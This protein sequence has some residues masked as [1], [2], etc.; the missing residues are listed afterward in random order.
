M[1]TAGTY[2]I[3]NEGGFI[4]DNLVQ[5]DMYGYGNLIIFEADYLVQMYIPHYQS[6]NKYALAVRSSGIGQEGWNPWAAFVADKK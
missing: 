3:G 6:Y 2:T 5:G 4:S 1:K